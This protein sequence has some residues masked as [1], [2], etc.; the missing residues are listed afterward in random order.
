MIE[1]PKEDW[2]TVRFSLLREVRDNF[3]EQMNRVSVLMECPVNWKAGNQ[4]EGMTEAIA[5]LTHLL[6][7]L[8]DE[9]FKP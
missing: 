3:R 7:E 8:P 6:A 2:R 4:P 9:F 5:R 1:K